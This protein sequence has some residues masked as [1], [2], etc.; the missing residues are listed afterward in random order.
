ML[1]KIDINVIIK[2]AYD[3][4]NAILDI[5]EQDFD[6]VEKEDNSPL[7]LADKA[8]N[9]VIISALKRLYPN[10]PFIS[11]EEKATAYDERKSWEYF[12]LIDPLDGTKEF[13]KKN[14][15][16]TVNIAL[17]RNK[18]SVLGVIYVPVTDEIYFAIEGQGAFKVDSGGG[19]SKLQVKG[20]SKESLKIVASRSH[21]SKEVE[22]YIEEKRNHYDKVDC[23]SAGSSLKFCLVAEGI[24]D[25]YPRLGPTMEWD[26][27]AGQ[28]I[29]EEAGGMVL[30]NGEKLQYNKE[31]LR[32]PFFIVKS[33]EAI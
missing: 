20:H 28:I 14:G 25:V 18:V 5:Y 4:G 22:E 12:W 16:F 6:V 32:N 3:A 26:T 27:A 1:D 15:E 19:K 30:D 24:A 23:V 11:E 29:V 2:V 33:F 9:N 13:I 7:T 31:V 21:L 10:I 17:V 8:S